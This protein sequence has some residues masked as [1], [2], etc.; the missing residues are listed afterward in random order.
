[1]SNTLTQRQSAADNGRITFECDWHTG[2]HEG[3]LNRQTPLKS[4]RG[5][6]LHVFVAPCSGLLGQSVGHTGQR[7]EGRRGRSAPPRRRSLGAR[8]ARHPRSLLHQPR[9][10]AASGDHE[11]GGAVAAPNLVVHEGIAPEADAGAAADA[12][13]G[14][15]HLG[16]WRT[17][18]QHGNHADRP[19]LL[20]VCRLAVVFDSGPRT[21]GQ[22]ARS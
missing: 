6:R 3:G 16:L 18:I 22:A 12:R 2:E 9:R 20:G 4:A 17:A 1:M 10:P 13:R 19:Q 21:Q 14:A 5:T 15:G 7:C 11:A 8:H